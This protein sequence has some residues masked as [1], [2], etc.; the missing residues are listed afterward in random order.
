[1]VEMIRRRLTR[2]DIRPRTLHQLPPV[3]RRGDH[4]PECGPAALEYN[5]GSR[6]PKPLDLGDRSN[7]VEPA[8]GAVDQIRA[9]SHQHRGYIARSRILLGLDIDLPD[10]LVFDHVAASQGSVPCGGHVLDL[11]EYEVGTVLR[12]L[13][14]TALGG[15]ERSVGPVLGEGSGGVTPALGVHGGTVERGLP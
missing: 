2:Q 10:E 14:R 15:D 9:V 5:C 13:V 3:A 6:P 8:I 12:H 11:L 4:P 7:R 1:M